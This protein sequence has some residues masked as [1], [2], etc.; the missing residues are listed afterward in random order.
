MKKHGAK[1]AA[2]RE[3]VRTAPK[4]GRWS[5]HGSDHDRPLL[6]RLETGTGMRAVRIA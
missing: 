6:L 5:L 2:R 3:K 4:T 1:Q